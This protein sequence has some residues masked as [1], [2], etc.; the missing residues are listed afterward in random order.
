MPHVS[1]AISV[2]GGTNTLLV[3]PW[4][5]TYAYSNY[6][7][8]LEELGL[9]DWTVDHILKLATFSMSYSREF[10]SWIEKV[11][12]G[13]ELSGE[14]AFW[15]WARLHAYTSIK[16]AL[17]D[18]LTAEAVFSASWPDLDLWGLER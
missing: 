6:K 8:R 7:P 17:P 11:T 10:V 12:N 2:V 18:Y 9:E 3:N 5:L 15:T 4:V 1:V 13:Q 14:E 16:S